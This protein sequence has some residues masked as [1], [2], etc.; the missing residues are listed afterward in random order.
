MKNYVLI[1]IFVASV[2]VSWFIW[3]RSPDYIRQG[4]PLLVV[5]LTCLFLVFTFGI[6]RFL[7]LRRADRFVAAFLGAAVLPRLF[8]VLGRVEAIAESP[9]T[10]EQ[11]P[12]HELRSRGFD[13]LRDLLARLAERHPNRQPAGAPGGRY[14]GRQPETARAFRQNRSHLPRILPRGHRGWRGAGFQRPGHRPGRQTRTGGRP[15]EAMAA[16]GTKYDWSG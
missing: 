5:G 9:V 1:P 12:P 10:V 8:P 7:V 13:A 3:D 14:S 2:I 4:G 11:V 16:N 15:C 6:E